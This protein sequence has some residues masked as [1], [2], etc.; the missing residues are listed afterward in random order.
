MKNIEVLTGIKFK[1]TYGNE[2]TVVKGESITVVLKNKDCYKGV[3][4]FVGKY[5][6]D[7]IE[8]VDVICIDTS[9][10]RMSYSV[11]IIKVMDIEYLQKNE[12]EQI[13]FDV[14]DMPPFA[15]ILKYVSRAWKNSSKKDREEII[16]MLS[17]IK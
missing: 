7:G 11:E 8:P 1:D 6:E 16:K 12:N 9:K 2:N 4:T 10:S 17:G 14:D 3:L 15:D 5:N 13:K